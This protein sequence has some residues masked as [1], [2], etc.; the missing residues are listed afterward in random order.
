MIN[1]TKHARIRMEERGISEQSVKR[2]LGK[3]T[4][5]A[6]PSEVTYG[7]YKVSHAG[8][9]VILAVDEANNI[10]ILTTYKAV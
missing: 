2:A 10:I 5:T 8:I 7:C 6:E 3:G 9:V 4:A 1:F